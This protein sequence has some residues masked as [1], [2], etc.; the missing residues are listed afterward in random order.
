MAL[1]VFTDLVLYV[2]DHVHTGGLGL[3]VFFLGVP[4]VAYAAAERR[5][6]SLRLALV[7]ALL[8]ATA[9]RSLWSPTSGSFATGLGLVLGFVVLMRLPRI[10]VPEVLTAALRGVVAIPSRVSALLRGSLR[11][12]DGARVGRGI[13]LPVVVPTALCLAFV[14]VFALANPVVSHALA[15]GWDALARLVTFPSPGRVFTWL[16]AAAAAA[17]LLRPALARPRGT[18]HAD[19]TTIAH[20]IQLAVARNAF[21]ALNALFAA[22]HALD[23]TYLWAGS[24][25]PGTTTQAYAHQGAF[26]LT[27][28]LAML[29]AVVGV[30]FRGALAHDA[31]AAKARALAYAWAAQGLLL[32]IGTYRRIGIHVT[33]SGLSDLRIVG[34]LGT[35]LV[36]SGLVL[37][38]WKL[39]HQ[40]TTT[41]LLRRQLDAFA[42][43]VVVYVLFPTHLVASHVNVARITSG[44]YRPLLHMFRQ[45]KEVESAAELLP[46]LDHPDKRVRQGVAALLEDEREVLAA[47]VASRTWRAYDV[48][49]PRTLAALEAARPR[50]VSTVAGVDPQA[51][52]RVLLEISRVA[53]EDRSLEEVW[54]VRAADG[55]DVRYVQ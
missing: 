16:V 8:V 39:H 14:L 5:R 41:W 46:L 53:N 24:P 47:D 12:L 38:V 23:A 54:A 9:L 36:A 18:E 45:S 34:I 3:A 20:E 19:T 50:L 49:S 6:P 10:H 43:G 22:Y 26:W 48:A 21:V 44:E 1:V 29:T 4:A 27:V 51:A 31:R 25:P 32:A 30:L 37:V 52:R 55:A 17:A 28:A 35:T 7:A 15:T 2:G 40:R 11:V 13:V 33:K 42:I